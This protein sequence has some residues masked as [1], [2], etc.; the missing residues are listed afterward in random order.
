M[1]SERAIALAEEFVASNDAVVAFAQ[2]CDDVQ[3]VTM[4]PGEDWP[5]GVVIHHI[6]EG[7]AQMAHWLTAMVAGDGVPDTNDD[8]DGRNVTHAE[9]SATVSIAET[10]ALLQ[11]NSRQ[12]ETFIRQLSDEELDRTAPFGPAGGQ[13]LPVFQLVS[14]S[15]GHAQ[16]HLAHAEA[17]VR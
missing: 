8:I 17:A 6:A 11:E 16:G 15:F 13:S 14:A 5:V 9:R 7:H 4:V 2:S 10:V 1:P 3:W 12:I